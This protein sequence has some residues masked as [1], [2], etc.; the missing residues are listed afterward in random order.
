MMNCKSCLGAASIASQR[1]EGGGEAAAATMSSIENITTTSTTVL[2][3]GGIQ[4]IW[5][6]IYV[7][8]F[9]KQRN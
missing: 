2:Q 6:Y 3:N 4:C 8:S 1:S 5:M 7:F 9:P